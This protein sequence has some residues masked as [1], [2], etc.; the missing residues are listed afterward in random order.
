MREVIEQTRACAGKERK[1]AFLR[2][3]PN[4]RP[5][6]TNVSIDSGAN[7]AGREPAHGK[8]VPLKH[9]LKPV[10]HRPPFGVEK[11]CEL[12]DHIVGVGISASVDVC[13]AHRRRRIVTKRGPIIGIP[14]DKLGTPR[15][16]FV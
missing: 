10:K 15:D 9:V 1:R 4:P 8:P 11:S 6:D 7:V 3:H 14:G 5:I 12:L 13:P 2:A 16:E